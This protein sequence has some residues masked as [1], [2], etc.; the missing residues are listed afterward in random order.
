MVD[1][2]QFE[3]K[4][5]A[6][7]PDKIVEEGYALQTA[8]LIG[9][10]VNG[11]NV[12]NLYLVDDSAPFESFNTFAQ[13]NTDDDETRRDVTRNPRARLY[14][15]TLC[16]KLVIE[17]YLQNPDLSVPEHDKLHQLKQAIEGLYASPLWGTTT[18]I[19]NIK[20]HLLSWLN[21]NALTSTNPTQAKELCTYIYATLTICYLHGAKRLTVQQENE[22][23]ELIDNAKDKALEIERLQPAGPPPPIAVHVPEEEKGA[24]SDRD[25]F[26][27][28]EPDRALPI[29]LQLP[30]DANIDRTVEE[31]D[32]SEDGDFFDAELP[33]DLPPPEEDEDERFETP[34]PPPPITLQSCLDERPIDILAI[35]ELSLLDKIGQI[36][37]FLNEV[38]AGLELL[39]Q[40][41]QQESAL[42]DQIKHAQ[43]IFEAVERNDQQGR[44]QDARDLIRS[45]QESLANLLANANAEEREEWDSIYAAI[46]PSASYTKAKAGLREMSNYTT[47]LFRKVTSTRVQQRVTDLFPETPDS[48][49]KQA[50]RN[51]AQ[52]RIMALRGRFD[53]NR[54]RLL[55]GRLDELEGEINSCLNQ[56]CGANIEAKE[57]F[58]N[59]FISDIE[60][61]MRK[62]RLALQVLA[63]LEPLIT[64]IATKQGKLKECLG[65]NEAIDA[66]ILEYD[67]IFVTLSLFLSH[68][69]S[70]IFKTDTADKIDQARVMKGQV[71]QW[72][73]DYQDE[74]DKDIDT[75]R[76][77]QHINSL[78]QGLV[79]Q[80]LTPP[81]QPLGDQ[82]AP[83]ET[84][85]AKF[86]LVDTLFK[87]VQPPQLPAPPQQTQTLVV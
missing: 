76:K 82:P 51:L 61:L 87:R 62:N 2:T 12:H 47:S 25:E 23:R 72:E 41:K 81:N 32:E 8:I 14:G 77:N 66:F 54:S 3:T 40:K 70:S 74:V 6:W 50:L 9:N 28:I 75:I 1:V 86:E 11:R 33:R 20:L 60:E 39:K 79:T 67:S 45:H 84:F 19:T 13:A 18:K 68:Y 36:K 59:A 15:A 52:N 85:L 38:H 78:K 29:A 17:A 24:E 63:A 58:K 16:L 43:I 35:Q 53:E 48:V 34:P 4:F 7:R 49:C 73:I 46:T 31:G 37:V 30:L 22:L 42:G 80:L 71:V 10:Y 5:R 64:R 56:L 65:V 83:P 27:D 44:R 57:L 21:E 55:N 69:I 26:F